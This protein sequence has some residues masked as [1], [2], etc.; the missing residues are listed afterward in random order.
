VIYKELKIHRLS[1][2]Q[3]PCFL[4][5]S[6]PEALACC[7]ERGVPADLNSL[8]LPVASYDVITSIDT[9]YHRLFPPIAIY[10]LLR[11]LL[12]AGR[13]PEE[14]RS[15]VAPLPGPVNGLL[16]LFAQLENLIIPHCPIPV[17]TSVFVVARR[18]E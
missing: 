3:V 6:S 5:L 7:R 12:T 13:S 11:R 8:E 18:Q 9:L 16:R 1:Q 15:D 4:V 14:V 2:A 10:R 17:G